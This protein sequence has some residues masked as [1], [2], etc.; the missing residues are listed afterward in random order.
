MSDPASCLEL[1][2]L[3]WVLL[4]FVFCTGYWLSFYGRFHLQ[5]SDF[6]RKKNDND[7]VF[8]TRVQ[9]ILNQF[10]STFGGN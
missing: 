6:Y 9:Q 5:F 4:D 3:V 8:G 7:R 1:S 10:H 2:I